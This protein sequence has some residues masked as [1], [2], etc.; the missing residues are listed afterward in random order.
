MIMIVVVE[1]DDDG[2]GAQRPSVTK[3]RMKAH[4]PKRTSTRLD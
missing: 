3:G 2:A 4:L 1:D